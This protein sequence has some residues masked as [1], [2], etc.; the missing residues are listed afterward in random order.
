M[1]AAELVWL[2]KTLRGMD[3]SWACRL[4]RSAVGV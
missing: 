1:P 4:P 3:W 2:A